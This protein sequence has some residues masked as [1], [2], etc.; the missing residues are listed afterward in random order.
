VGFL[1]EHTDFIF[2]VIA[3]ETGFIS[4]FLV[5]ALFITLAIAGIRVAMR[6]PDRFGMLLAA[7]IT[8][9][10]LSQA[11]FNVGQAIGRGRSW[12]C[13]CRSCRRVARR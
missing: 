3:E 11:F 1:P 4:A 10:F 9:W 2:A 6:A 12:V 7:G 13:R 5:I 8:T